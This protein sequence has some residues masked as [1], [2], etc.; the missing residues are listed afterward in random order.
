MSRLN[1]K[2]F[3]AAAVALLGSSAVLAQET[4]VAPDG[5]QQGQQ[6]RHH[7][8]HGFMGKHLVEKLGLSTAQQAQLA[9]LKT[10]LK[11]EISPVRTTIQAKH[12]E[13]KA[14]WSAPTKDRSAILAKEV[15]IDQQKSIIRTAMVDF[16][17]AFNN[18]LTPAQ[19]SQLAQLRANH[20]G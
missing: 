1:T 11:A 5:Q 17:I 9:S 8:R 10:N 2:I 15:E 16:R 18:L 7:R 14:L 20:R 13:L 3:I 6:F 12:A 19:Q 4:T